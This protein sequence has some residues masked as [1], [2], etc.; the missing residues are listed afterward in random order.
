MNIKSYIPSF[1]LA[2]EHFRIDARGRVVLD[3]LEKIIPHR[4]GLLCIYFNI[5]DQAINWIY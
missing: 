1:K 4:N 5:K 3:E 2:F